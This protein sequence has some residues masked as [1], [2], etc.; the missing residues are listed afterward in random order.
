MLRVVVSRA[1]LTPLDAHAT[2]TT[3]LVSSA[4]HHRPAP[5]TPAAAAMD[6]DMRAALLQ[7]RAEAEDAAAAAAVA[8]ASPPPAHASVSVVGSAEADFDAPFPGGEWETKHPPVCMPTLNRAELDLVE[9][10]A[11]HHLWQTQSLLLVLL[12]SSLF[13]L[14]ATY[15]VLRLISVFESADN[16]FLGSRTSLKSRA[17]YFGIPAVASIVLN[18]LVYFGFRAVWKKKTWRVLRE[19]AGV[20]AMLRAIKRAVMRQGHE[21]GDAERK[22]KMM[23]PTTTSTAAAVGVLDADGV[24]E[25]SSLPVPAVGYTSLAGSNDRFSHSVSLGS[26]PMHLSSGSGGAAE[27]LRFAAADNG[28][29]QQ[30]HRQQAETEQDM[31]RKALQQLALSYHT[32]AAPSAPAELKDDDTAAAPAGAI[33]LGALGVGSYVPPSSSSAAGG[34]YNQPSPPSAAAA[35]LF[36]VPLLADNART[37]AHAFDPPPPSHPYFYC[38]ANLLHPS[39]IAL[40]RQHPSWSHHMWALVYTYYLFELIPFMLFGIAT[41]VFAQP[42]MQSWE[43]SAG[44]THAADL[45]ISLFALCCSTSH[46]CCLVCPCYLAFRL[47]NPVHLR[48]D[49]SCQD[50][51]DDSSRLFRRQSEFQLVGYAVQF[52]LVRVPAGCAVTVGDLL[53]PLVRHHH[54][55]LGHRIGGRRAQCTGRAVRFG[56]AVILAVRRI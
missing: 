6:G 40:L 33:K 11:P 34:G 32:G 23:Q 30:L 44:V 41:A 27:Y 36:P 12:L 2:H 17:K 48:C 20:G 16:L 14:L 45:Q 43:V 53:C 4:L 9:A 24:R 19:V 47:F 50:A 18:M 10:H 26:T 37:F 13:T 5:P 25:G 38:T 1:S 8:A 3:R 54:R 39:D 28:Q 42:D 49:T 55:R 52:E 15:G 51:C 31:S 35:L 7:P 46:C 22:K 56:A 21:E 29:L